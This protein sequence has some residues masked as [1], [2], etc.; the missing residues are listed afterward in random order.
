[1]PQMVVAGPLEEL[2][3]TDELRLQP[4]AFRHLRFRQPLT[5]TTA[6][7]LRQ[8]RKRA[9]VDL[10][11]LELS[12]QLRAGDRCKPVAGSRY[13]DQFV[14]LVVPTDQRVERPGSARVASDH[15]FLTAVHAHF[16]P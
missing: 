16:H 6:P 1:M 14:A 2:E 13:V 8:I 11:P 5:P 3:L 9:L 4:L 15:E 10:E 12:E 7:R